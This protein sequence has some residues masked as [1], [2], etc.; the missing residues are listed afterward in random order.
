M[1]SGAVTIGDCWDQ[2]LSGSGIAGIPFLLGSHS[3]WDRGLPGPHSCH[4]P[5]PARIWICWDPIPAGIGDCWDQ[6]LSGSSS[7]RDPIPTKSR[8][9][10]TQSRSAAAT[11]AMRAMLAQPSP[12]IVGIFPHPRFPALPGTAAPLPKPFPKSHSQHL[13]H[14]EHWNSQPAAPGKG[15]K[16]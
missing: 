11:R 2:E 3:C 7:C 9:F 5:I 12:G 1:G 8:N 16:N 6:G 15:R 4:V 13:L 10:R 14:W